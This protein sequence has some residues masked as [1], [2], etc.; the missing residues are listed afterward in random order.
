MLRTEPGLL[1]QRAGHIAPV[2]DDVHDP[3]LGKGGA[4]DVDEV[5][6][7]RSLLDASNGADEADAP[8]NGEDPA[9][10]S[11]GLG[12]LEPDEL[13]NRGL[14]R[15][16]LP[17]IDEARKRTDGPGEKRRSRAW[18]SHDEHEP[19]V[20]PSEALAQRRSPARR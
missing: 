6:E 16:D 9:Q 13:G 11:C 18:R 17:E 3:G 8:R 20:E 12:R 7:L 15:R 2:A 4:D 19:V 5:G 10:A 1:E 14:E